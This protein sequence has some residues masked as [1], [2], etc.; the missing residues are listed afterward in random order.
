LGDAVLNLVVSEYLFKENKKDQEG[1]LSK[2]RT[3]FVARAHLNK[4][5]KQL[6]KKTKIKNRLKKIPENIYGNT[7]EAIIGA[8]YLDKGFKQTKVFIEG[9]IINSK[10]K[11]SQ[12]NVDYKS[13][14]HETAQKKNQTIQYKII[15]T[16]GP[17]HKKEFSI[18]IFVDNVNIAEAKAYSK[19]QAE[20]MA[21]RKALQTTR[22]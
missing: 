6:I 20:Q 15:N 3:L 18:A 4:I 22:Q 10:N 12:K 19:K 11:N 2:K 14:L 8:I 1:T 7:L 17:D 21:A 13:I 16:Q 9:N 5:G